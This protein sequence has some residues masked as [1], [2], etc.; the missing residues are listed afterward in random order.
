MSQNKTVFP[1]L[2]QEGDFNPNQSFSG[3]GQP[4]SRPLNQGSVKG[5]QIARLKD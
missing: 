3:G 5:F 2:G 1:G 4:Y